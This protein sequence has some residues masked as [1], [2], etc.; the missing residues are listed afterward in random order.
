MF[1]LVGMT[2]TLAGPEAATLGRALHEVP[3]S[4]AESRFEQW[5]ARAAMSVRAG[6]S[7]M[8]LGDDAMEHLGL[9][10]SPSRYALWGAIPFIYALDRARR[11]IPGATRLTTRLGGAWQDWHSQQLL[12]KSAPH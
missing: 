12:D 1:Y 6:I 7:H 10:K 11:I 4:L 5:Q 8:F 9:P 3:L 2:Q